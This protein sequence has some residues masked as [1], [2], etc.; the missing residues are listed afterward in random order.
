MM[1][2]RNLR[3]FLRAAQREPAGFS[4]NSDERE[5]PM[6]EKEAAEFTQRRES[7]FRC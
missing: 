6:E 7:L 5:R 3:E 2:A 4:D 1:L